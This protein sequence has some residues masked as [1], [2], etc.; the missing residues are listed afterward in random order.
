MSSPLQAPVL[1][2]RHLFSDWCWG[3]TAAEH[4]RTHPGCRLRSLLPRSNS[5]RDETFALISHSGIRQSKTYS[6]LGKE[7]EEQAEF[8]LIIIT[9]TSSKLSAYLSCEGGGSRQRQELMEF[10]CR[11]QGTPPNTWAPTT[12][13]RKH[14]LTSQG[15]WACPKMPLKGIFHLEQIDAPV[16]QMGSERAAW[17]AL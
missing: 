2:S 1:T 4:A 5:K 8:F 3:N 13:S 9:K 12:S 14:K 7:K 17:W 6:C 16:R 10:I 11:S 15:S